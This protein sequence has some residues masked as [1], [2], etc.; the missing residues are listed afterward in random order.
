MKKIFNFY[1]KAFLI[2][3]FISIPFI[4]IV[5]EDLN[6]KIFSYK[7]WIATFFPQFIYILYLFR[8]EKLFNTFKTNF[9]GKGLYNNAI[10]ITCLIP[11]IIYSFLV[12]FKLIKVY[13]Y[14]NWDIEIIVYFI[15]IF[16]SALLEE[17]LFRFIPYKVL[18][19][20]ISIKDVLLVSL[21]FSFFHLFNPNINVVGLV[22]VAIAGVFFSLIYLKSNS[23]LLTS[24][25]HAFWNF[26]IGCLLGSN[27]SGIKVIS[28]LEYV[29]QKPFF[30]SGGDFGFEGSII[31]TLLFLMSCA[32]LYLLKPMNPLK[33]FKRNVFQFRSRKHNRKFKFDK[34]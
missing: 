27:I 31:T 3:S 30:L 18:V 32:F 22:N 19:N 20:D 29:P 2:I 14:S 9:L 33:K 13:N 11:F 28:I 8:K 23:I 16:L 10:L 24:F 4:F 6:T 26:S 7:I 25:I 34:A 17:I 21:L 15:L 5:F 12:G 1:I